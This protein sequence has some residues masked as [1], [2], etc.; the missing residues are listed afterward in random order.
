MAVD[1]IECF[2]PVADTHTHVLVDSWFHCK[3]VRKAAQKRNWDLSGGLKSN[4]TMRLVRTAAEHG[5]SSQ[6]MLHS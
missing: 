5:S 1:E 4:R 6:N 2:D 3:R